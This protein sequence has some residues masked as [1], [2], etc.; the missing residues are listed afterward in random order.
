MPMA[1]FR[2]PLAL[3]F[4][5]VFVAHFVLAQY[6]AY[7]YGFDA[8]K[9][10]KRQLAS[11]EP[12]PVVTG[13]EGGETIRPRQEIRQL[14]QDKELWTLYILGLSLMQF[15]DQSSP[16][17]WYG[18]TGIHGIPH[19]TWG[20]VT[21]TPGNEETGYCTHSSILF[22]TWH[23]PYLALYE[24]VL[25][26]LI[27]NI[28]KWWPEGEPR[29]RYQAAALR[30]RIPYWDWASSP[31]SGQ[32]V[33]PLSVGGSPYVD[34]NGP[35]GVQR[36][37]NP[38]FS[39]SFKP[40]NATAFLQDP[41]DIWTTTLRSPT[42]S[43]NKAQSNNSL[44]AVNFDQNLDSIGQRLYILFSNY[45]N[46]STFSN[47]AW[48]P[49][50][51]NG[52]FDSLE[53]IH[54]TVHNLAGG[55][56]LG[57][58]NAQGGHMAYIPYSSFDPIFFLHHAMVDRIFAIWQSLY[59][60]SYVTPMQAYIASYTTSRGEFQTAATPLT[61]FYFNANGTFWT[62]D[63]VRDHT[64]FG[65]TYPELVGV[66]GSVPNSQSRAL[67][68]RARGRV[69]AAINRLYGPSTPSSLYRKELRA[70]RLGPGKKVPSNLPV[71]RVFS[72][73]GQYREWLANVRVKKQALDGPFF[74][75][76]FLGE[77]PKDPKE[78]ASAKNH[79]G[80]M[81]VFASD[82]RYGESKMDGM[83]EVMVSGTVPLTKALVE[84]VM[85]T[86]RFGVGG[87]VKGIA[88]SAGG[89]SVGGRFVGFEGDVGN[90]FRGEDEGYGEDGDW[91]GQGEVLRSLDPKDVEPFLRRNL[92]VNIVKMDGK[93][94]MHGSYVEGLGIHVVSSR[95]RAAR[96]EEELPAW[97]QAESG[98]DVV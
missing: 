85:G 64:R 58:P 72:G 17:S 33:L 52:S 61:P 2:L 74:I 22:P 16:V 91:V 13:A 4:L 9:L 15:T 66:S 84:K 6:G 8:A 82:E 63:M 41:W 44:V 75:H 5:A 95:V 12:V 18:I 31:P 94:V 27:Q 98:F 73:N 96:V 77:A 56:G 92:V 40:L 42:T 81:G 57:Q 50:I 28:A 14:E 86:G 80:S 11:Q 70:G 54:D 88:A 32:S 23:R 59:P 89:R 20:G 49:Y 47:N 38:L 51:N 39:Y 87:G 30:F 97:G 45:G 26:N 37:A 67:S 36:I 10:I 68:R 48:I 3:L 93:V 7:N 83:D 19:Q 24:Q 76:L 35:N 65:Y 78:W 53:A 25:Y 79:V 1:R 60:S 90:G 55:G 71:G 46:Y 43:D 34:V 29:N 21:P 62:S 69:M